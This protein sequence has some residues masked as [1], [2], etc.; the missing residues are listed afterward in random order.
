M[1]GKRAWAIYTTGC[2]ATCYITGGLD[3]W[4]NIGCKSFIGNGTAIKGRTTT[5]AIVFAARDSDENRQNNG[6]CYYKS[7]THN[8]YFVCGESLRYK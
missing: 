1:I 6:Q 8:Y 7:L 3:D 5:T 4:T 2:M